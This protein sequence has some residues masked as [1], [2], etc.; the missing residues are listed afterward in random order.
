MKLVWCL[1][2]INLLPLFVPEIQGRIVVVRQCQSDAASYV[3]SCQDITFGGMDM[4]TCFCDSDGCNAASYSISA[5]III[6]LVIS[7]ISWIIVT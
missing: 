3:G 7:V 4:R 2:K 5:S 6:L 1:T